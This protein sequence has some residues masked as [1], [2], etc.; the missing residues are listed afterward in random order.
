[1]TVQEE[2]ARLEQ[3]A[4]DAY[5]KMYDVPRYSA[6]DC[7]DDARSFLTRAIELAA[8]ENL[9]ETVERLKA[10]KDH[11]YNVYTHQFR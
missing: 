1:M 3:S 5:T 9:T 8:R 7:Y 4:E 2:I 10:R 11:I 6:R